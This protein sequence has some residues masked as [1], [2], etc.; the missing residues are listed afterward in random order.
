MIANYKT[1]DTPVGSVIKGGRLCEYENAAAVQSVEGEIVY[2]SA[3]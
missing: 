1:I 3:T 2:D